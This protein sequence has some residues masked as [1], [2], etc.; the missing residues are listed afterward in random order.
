MSAIRAKTMDGG[1]TQ[2]SSGSLNALKGRL[3]GNLLTPST[4]GYNTSRQLWNGMIDK[5]PA[6]IARCAGTADVMTSINYAR[7]HHVL[8]AVRGGGHNVAGNALI[9]GGMVIDLS[10]MRNVHVDPARRL[11]RAAGGATLGDLD[12]ETQAFGL[13]TPVGLVSRTGVAGLTLGGG[14]G[15][16]TRRYGLT[17]DNLRSMEVVT[18]DSQRH[19]ASE[20]QNPE[21]FW[22]LKGGGGNFGIVTSFE[23]E[24]HPVG[25]EVMLSAVFYPAEKAAATM[26]DSLRSNR[27]TTLTISSD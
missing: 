10:A 24:L 8:T 22:A 27:S 15:W 25:P 2:L 5:H 13:A 20:K 7:E 1:E 9:E 3:R 14:F 4:P 17:C 23:Y 21:L 11:A 6:L 19:T 12:H 18:A 26:H 16:L